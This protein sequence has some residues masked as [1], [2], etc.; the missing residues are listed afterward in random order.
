MPLDYILSQINPARILKHNLRFILMLSSHQRL[1][2]PGDL[3]PSRFPT[4]IFY[5]FLFCT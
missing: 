5:A 1:G 4:K 3:L 2:L